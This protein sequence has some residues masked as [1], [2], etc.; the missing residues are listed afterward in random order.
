M[1]WIHVV[2]TNYDDAK[3]KNFIMCTIKKPGVSGDISCDQLGPA[4]RR[5][6]KVEFMTGVG[7]DSATEA[8]LDCAKRADFDAHVQP[9]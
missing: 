2:V 1:F 9:N 6:I 8:V 5:L 4:T 3:Y 7:V